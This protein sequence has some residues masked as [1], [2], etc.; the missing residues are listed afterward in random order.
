LGGFGGYGGFAG[1]AGKAEAEFTGH[2]QPRSC[3]RGELDLRSIAGSTGRADKR[4]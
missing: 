1:N 2:T 4:L 3:A